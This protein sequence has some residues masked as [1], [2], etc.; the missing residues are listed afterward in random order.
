MALKSRL[1]FSIPVEFFTCAL[2]KQ[3][4]KSA[5]LAW[6]W[7]RLCWCLCPLTVP[8]RAVSDPDVSVTDGLYAT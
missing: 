3:Y 4:Q 8:V 2:F 6:T 1:M 7:A 5:G